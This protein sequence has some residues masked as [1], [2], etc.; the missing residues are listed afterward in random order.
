LRALPSEDAA[1]VRLMFVHGWTRDGVKRALHLVDLPRERVA[2][3]LGRLRESL[4]AKPI[5]AEGRRPRPEGSGG[6]IDD[7]PDA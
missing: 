6:R 5:G 3:I 2:A 7:T 1:I 4:S